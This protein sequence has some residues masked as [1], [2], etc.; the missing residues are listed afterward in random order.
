MNDLS[1]KLRVLRAERQL[2]LREVE[3]ATGVDKNTLS[4]LERG[5][6]KPQTL[7]IGKLATGYG[8]P[9][10]DLLALLCAPKSLP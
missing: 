8:V 5:V 10:E 4:C 7:T 9:V 6:R 1:A 2:T 3:E